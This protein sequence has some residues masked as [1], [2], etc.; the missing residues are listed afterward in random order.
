PFVL[1]TDMDGIG[2]M[3][4]PL[5]LFQGYWLIAGALM[6]VLGSTLYTRGLSSTLKEK[7]QLALERF[8]GSTRWGAILLFIVLLAT[9]GYI[10]YNVSYRNEY[11]TES[12]K[13]KRSAIEEQQLKRYGD[14]P[15]PWIIRMRLA[16]DLFPSE[17]RAASH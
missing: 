13:D 9:G 6:V 4:K 3:L 7:R 15:Q 8:H 1:F 2:H 5:V 12:E 17:Q 14:L 16:A 10:Y 11:L